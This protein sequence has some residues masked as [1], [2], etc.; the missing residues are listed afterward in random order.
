MCHIALTMSKKV[1]IARIRLS[2]LQDRHFQLSH[3]AI[4]HTLYNVEFGRQSKCSSY[5]KRQQNADTPGRG[6]E[7]MTL[8]LKV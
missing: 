6:L 4:W 5:K 7:P 2:C 8:R 1:R 3:D